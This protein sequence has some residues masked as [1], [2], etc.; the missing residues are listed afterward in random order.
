MNQVWDRYRLAQLYNW[1]Y[2]AVVSGT[3]DATNEHGFAWMSQM[4]ARHSAMTLELD[5][6]GLLLE[7]THAAH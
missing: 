6:M 7:M 5:I 4:V 2:V 3:L 1:V